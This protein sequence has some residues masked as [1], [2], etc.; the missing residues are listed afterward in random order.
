MSEKQRDQFEE[1]STY[2]RLSK[3]YIFMVI[4]LDEKESCILEN[5]FKLTR[6]VWKENKVSNKLNCKYLPNMLLLIQIV[7]FFLQYT[8]YPTHFLSIY[9]HSQPPNLKSKLQSTKCQ[10]KPNQ[11]KLRYPSKEKSK[12]KSAWFSDVP[13]YRTYF[14]A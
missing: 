8:Q 2:L 4:T 11:I 9:Y 10:G 12:I 3:R 6:L 14:L 7:V 13:I 5:V 1:N